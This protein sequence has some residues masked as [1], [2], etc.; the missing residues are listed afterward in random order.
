MILLLRCFQERELGRRVRNSNKK[1]AFKAKKAK[2]IFKNI[3]VFKIEIL[4]MKVKGLKREPKKKNP[5]EKVA[6]TREE[7]EIQ[8]TE[9]VLEARSQL[10]TLMDIYDRYNLVDKE[11][12]NLD[13]FFE[14][15]T[16]SYVK[17][18]KRRI[19][20]SQQKSKTD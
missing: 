12:F 17:R 4:K 5:L 19:G 2:H 15:G 11:N 1:E 8:L 18:P 7:F 9:S 6:V 20:F 16:Y 13:Y 3:N 14:D 10:D